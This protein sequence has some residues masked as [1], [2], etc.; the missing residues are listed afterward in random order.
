MK[1]K[2]DF[3]LNHSFGVV[4]RIIFELVLNGFTDA[5]EI[6]EALP[7]FS[8]VVLAN[9]I[10]HLIN[11][12]VLSAN[13]DKRRLSLTDPI[14]AIISSCIE[15]TYDLDIDDNLKSLMINQAVSMDLAGK[16][17]ANELKSSIL[18]TL[19]PD[20][21]LYMYRDSLDFILLD[22][23]RGDIIG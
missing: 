5:Y 3:Q 11:R 22:G 4:E 19:V 21:N 20:V 14:R 15:N 1:V 7:I 9:G 8:D 12:Q 10:K 13:V 16:Q 18:R 2:F 17:Q 6:R 23:S